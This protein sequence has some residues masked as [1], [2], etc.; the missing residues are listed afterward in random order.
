HESVEQ[1]LEFDSGTR[2]STFASGVGLPGRVWAS[3]EPA[4]IED[5]V[6]DAN[7]PRAAAAARDG[8]HGA[9]AFPIL[10]GHE[11]IGV[12]EFFSRVNRAPDEELLRMFATIGSQ[13][14]QY[15]ERHRAEEERDR[16]FTLSLDMLCI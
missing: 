5:V 2:T 1:F 7:F 4:W 16:F 8:L 11:T 10:V 6:K 12:I 3:G 13:I 9:F 15:L 14:G